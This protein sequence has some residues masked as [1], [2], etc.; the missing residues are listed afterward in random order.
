[1]SGIE[2]VSGKRYGESAE[3]TR[4]FR[5]IA[6]HIRASV[7]LIGDPRG[8]TPSNVGQG[9]IVRRLVRR[10]IREGRRLGISGPFVNPIAEIVIG[11][12]GGFYPELE[13]NRERILGELQAEER[14]FG[15]T[16]EKGLKEFEKMIKDRVISGQE[17]FDLFQTYGF[18]LEL[19][20]ELVGERGGNLDVAAFSEE[21][22]KHQELS[23]TASSGAFKGGL[24]DHSAE[25]TRLHTAT[26]LLHA[27]LRKVLGPQV[28]QKGS[29]ITAERLRF[30]FSHPSK[31]TADELKTVEDLVNEIIRHDLP[32]KR[33]EMTVEEAKK[34]GAI[35]LFGQKYGEK[36]SVYTVEG[37]SKEICGGPHIAHTGEL[38]SFKIQKEEAV[39]AGLRRIKAV[40]TG[41]RNG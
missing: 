22:K 39:S 18:P 37:F 1:L 23:R 21:F 31:M 9:Y 16:L 6:D 36:V 30:D 3:V 14:K 32:V 7:F 33:E 19:T 27:A 25:T 8:V 29:N 28:E 4:S 13:A 35:G 38:G 26:H 20:Q 11:E 41:I 5:V 24:A 40:V 17:A 2:T 15:Q 12:F 10:A 34:A